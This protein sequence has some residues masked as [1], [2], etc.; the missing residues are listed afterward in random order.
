MDEYGKQEQMIDHGSVRTLSPNE[1]KRH[2]ERLR[3][4]GY[5][6]PDEH[7]K[8]KPK[9]KCRKL[10]LKQEQEILRRLNRGEKPIDI[11]RHFSVSEGLIYDVKKKAKNAGQLQAN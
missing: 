1:I 5:L 11:A 10:S 3:R 8:P 9:S 6:E 2:E 4:L 7:F